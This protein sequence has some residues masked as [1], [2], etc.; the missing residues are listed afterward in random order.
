MVLPKLSGCGSVGGVR[1]EWGPEEQLHTQYCK[2]HGRPL[3]TERTEL[4]QFYNKK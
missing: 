1:L 4:K 3:P 2:E